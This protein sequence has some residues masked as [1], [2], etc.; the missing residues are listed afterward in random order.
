M[1]DDRDAT[2][3][4]DVFR[5]ARRIAQVGIERF[6][7]AS[8]SYFRSP[9][10]PVGQVL[11]MQGDRIGTHT[12]GH[13]STSVSLVLHGNYE[14]RRLTDDDLETAARW[15]AWAVTSGLVA[16]PHFDP[17]SDVKATACPGRHARAAIPTINARAEEILMAD[18]NWLDRWDPSLRG[19]G[20]K[21]G[22]RHTDPDQP[23]GTI[24]VQQWLALQDRVA[25][26]GIVAPLAARML[27][28]RDLDDLAA[29][30]RSAA[31]A[32]AGSDTFTG[33]GT[34]PTVENILDALAARLVD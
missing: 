3:H 24:P 13:N 11:V 12:G 9:A 5:D 18:D 20:E 16:L 17:H 19:I 21:Y 8:Y 34:A 31:Q 23:V 22:T 1:T 27:D 14:T 29:D 33:D 28:D 26:R 25:Q 30:I 2:V 15:L 32:A 10:G 6:G 7:R 4:D